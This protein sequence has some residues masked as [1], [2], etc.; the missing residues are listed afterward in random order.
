LAGVRA[1][2]LALA[3]FGK[4]GKTFEVEN[5]VR[6]YKQDPKAPLGYT[7]C[8]REDFKKVGFT[9]DI[10]TNKRVFDA[11]KQYNDAAMISYRATL[12]KIE[13]V[14]VDKDNAKFFFK[15]LMNGLDKCTTIAEKQKYVEEVILKYVEKMQPALLPILQNL[16]QP[17]NL[18]SWVSPIYLLKNPKGEWSPTDTKPTDEQL[19]Q[20]EALQMPNYYYQTWMARSRDQS[21]ISL[22]S[23]KKQMDKDFGIKI[24]DTSPDYK[25]KSRKEKAQELRT[26]APTPI[27]TVTTPQ[28]RSSM[29]FS[30]GARER[31]TSTPYLPQTAPQNPDEEKK[32][33]IPKPNAH[34]RSSDGG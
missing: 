23:W 14:I 7:L 2:A 1:S 19:K 22:E 10:V 11:F 3:T 30:K 32:S 33:S 9:Y 26:S 28:A 34:G 21:N 5:D 15:G 6:Y 12:E 16:P 18:K 24:T 13:K 8:N 31:T 17:V 25:A 20:G 27:T 29:L 4:S